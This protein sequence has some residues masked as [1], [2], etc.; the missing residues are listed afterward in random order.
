M[1][2][3]GCVYIVPLLESMALPPELAAATNPKSST[4][5]LDVFT[6][7]IADGVA[8]L[9]P[10]PGRLSWSALRRDLS[11][12]LS[13]SWCA[14]AR[15][16]R[17]SASA[18]APP[19]RDLALVE[20]HQ[21]RE[22]RLHRSGRHRPRHR[23]VGRPCSATRTASSAIAPSGTPASSMSTRRAPAPCSTSGSR[24]TCAASQAADPRSRPVLHPRLEGSR[25]RAADA[26]RRDGAVQSAG[27]RVPRALRRASSIRAS[28][29]RRPAAP[30][31]R[32]CSRCAA[33][34]CRSSWRTA[35]SS[36]A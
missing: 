29:M 34:R 9:R 7:V 35:R 20:L 30:A 2:E 5:R 16:C 22:A 25:A 12:D 3:T 36:A 19:G 23:A 32:P 33:T 18:S 10:D 1:L 4:G 11:A 24:S 21:P 17:R 13:R 27:R 6:R 31:P 28:A 15:G 26:C 8:G 14:R